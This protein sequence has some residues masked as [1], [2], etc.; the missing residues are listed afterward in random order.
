MTN[1]DTG[2]YGEDIA[3]NFLIN[4][5]FKILERNFRYSKAAEI[6]IIALKDNILHFVEVKTRS[7][8]A[9]GSPLEAVG[10]SKLASIFKCALFYLNKNSNNHKKFQIDVIGI[11][12]K[13]D[14]ENE[15]T[16]LEN[17]SIN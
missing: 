14:S 4:R 9:C 8:F 17:V 10:R 6:D 3:C 12:L 1:K 16:F 13:K 5:G 2:K 7:S 15:I 11:V